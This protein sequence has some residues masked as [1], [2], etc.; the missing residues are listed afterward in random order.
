MPL[1]GNQFWHPIDLDQG[2]LQATLPE[3]I[4]INDNAGASLLGE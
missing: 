4:S 3:W 1:A 2:L